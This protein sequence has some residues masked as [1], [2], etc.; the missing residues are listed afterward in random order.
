LVVDEEMRKI[1]LDTHSAS[2][3]KARAKA[4]GMK[5]LRDMGIDKVIEGITTPQEILRVTQEVEGGE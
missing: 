3:L 2:E 1:I 4:N 5:T